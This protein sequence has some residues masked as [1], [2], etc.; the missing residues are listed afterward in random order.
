MDDSLHVLFELGVPGH[1]VRLEFW[2]DGAG[3]SVLAKDVPVS[4]RQTRGSAAISLATATEL[5]GA[6]VVKVLVADTELAS[7]PFHVE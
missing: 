1:A 5:R 7:I 4:A 6:L 3:D 2:P